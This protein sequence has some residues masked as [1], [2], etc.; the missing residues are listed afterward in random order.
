M[1]LAFVLFKCHFTEKLPKSLILLGVKMDQ[2]ASDWLQQ[3][4]PK[5][6]SIVNF[7]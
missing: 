2:F 5:Y 6:Y 7:I 3:I 1:K 4:K